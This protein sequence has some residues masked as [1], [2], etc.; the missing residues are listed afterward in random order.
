MT[1]L[2]RYSRIAQGEEKDLEGQALSHRP[3]RAA[4]DFWARE[5]GRRN[6]G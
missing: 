3:G 6:E 1:V 4:R 2:S 5:S